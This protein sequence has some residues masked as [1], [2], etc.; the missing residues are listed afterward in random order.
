MGTFRQQRAVRASGPSLDATVIQPRGEAAPGP[1]QPARLL[2]VSG[3]RAGVVVALGSGD[4]TVGRGWDNDVVLPDISVSRR[5]AL[6]RR[7]GAEYV[8]LDQGSG[9]GTSVNGR[10]VET[11]W[12]RD[13]D[14]ISL[15]DSV[16]EFVAAGAMAVRSN[17]AAVRERRPAGGPAASRAAACAGLA[18]FLLGATVVALRRGQAEPG[19]APD[20]PVQAQAVDAA[21][22]SG[23][24]P[25]AGESNPASGARLPEAEAQAAAPAPAVPN[26]AVGG[27]RNEAHA[28]PRPARGKGGGPAAVGTR[29]ALQR[30]SREGTARREEGLPAE[31]IAEGEQA[32]AADR[33]VAAGRHRDELAAKAGE[34]YWSGYVAKDLD[35]DAARRAFRLVLALLPP[36]DETAVKAQRWLNRLEERTLAEE[37]PPPP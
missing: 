37:E 17:A 25:P 14:E 30:A 20:H 27:S 19:G 7:D 13:G 11:A 10:A 5:H 22:R 35:P 32:D 8:L 24:P 31:G 26:T 33:A 18:A 16:V 15:G 12:L 28:A 34:A 21:S 4:L 3:P 2:V 9:N 1:G 6:L 23:Q 36:G 29:A